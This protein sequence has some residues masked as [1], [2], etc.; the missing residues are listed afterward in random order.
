MSMLRSALQ[1][2][3]DG[4]SLEGGKTLLAWSGDGKRCLD[5]ES[6]QMN[7]VLTLGSFSG[8]LRWFGD[9]ELMLCQTG[10][11]NICSQSSYYSNTGRKPMFTF[12]IVHTQYYQYFVLELP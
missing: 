9:T 5:I 8:L 12:N 7:A 6:P 2:A 4:G 10:S 1:F 3:E 11:P